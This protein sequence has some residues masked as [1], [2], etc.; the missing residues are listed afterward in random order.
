MSLRRVEVRCCCQPKRLLGWLPVDELK[1]WEGSKVRFLVAPARTF[2]ELGAAPISELAVSTLE[3]PILTA[4]LPDAD[5][6]RRLAL[7]S[8]ETPIETLRRI[9]GFV[10]ARGQGEI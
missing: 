5:G 4:C 8:E 6:G 7:K 2:R 3:L 10:E 1:I 9:P